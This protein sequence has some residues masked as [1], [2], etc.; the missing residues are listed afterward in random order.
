METDSFK[1]GLKKLEEVANTK[2]VAI[3]CAEAVWWRCHRS[4]ISDILKA[5]SWRFYI[6]W[7]RIKRQNIP[8]RN[9]QK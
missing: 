1:E 6:L 3:M 8:I 7:E 9:Q 2:K 4:M 5:E